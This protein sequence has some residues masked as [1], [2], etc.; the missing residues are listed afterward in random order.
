[1]IKKIIGIVIAVIG[2]LISCWGL[3]VFAMSIYYNAAK[4]PHMGSAAYLGF[5]YG[6]AVI[7]IGAIP[8][9]VG[10]LLVKDP[11]AFLGGMELSRRHIVVIWVTVILASLFFGLNSK[12]YIMKE[13]DKTCQTY[14]AATIYGHPIGGQIGTYE[15]ISPSDKYAPRRLLTKSEKGLS[16][17]R[18]IAPYK[19]ALSIATLLIG[20]FVFIMMKSK[21]KQ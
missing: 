12:V 16:G 5:Y 10:F 11:K 13:D 6:L 15:K 3:W 14:Q 2:F 20:F 9:V 18:F 17:I 1:M 7:V 19:N 4:T 21:S 8:L